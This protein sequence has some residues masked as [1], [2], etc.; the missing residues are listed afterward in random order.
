MDITAF[1]SLAVML[2]SGMLVGALFDCLRAT[3][4]TLKI[5]HYKKLIII[6]EIIFW[7]IMGCATFYLLLVV[8]H[9]DWRV[10]DSLVQIAGIFI[11]S[12]IL[13][14]PSRFIGALLFKLLSIPFILI[15]HV[16]GFFLKVAIKIYKLNMRIVRKIVP[17]IKK[18]NNKQL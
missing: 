7:I 15:G 13:Y 17:D 3:A 6:I 9:G 10:V 4:I 14:K 18:R 12:T 11:Y 16:L 1:E 2:L 8:K 5:K